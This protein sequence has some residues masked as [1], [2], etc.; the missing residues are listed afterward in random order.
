[1][2]ITIRFVWS[3]ATP[4]DTKRW[5]MVPRVGDRVELVGTKAVR[6][7]DVLWSETEAGAQVTLR[8]PISEDETNPLDGWDI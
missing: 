7:I 6:V 1:M 3:D 5:P 2:A 4:I 8:R